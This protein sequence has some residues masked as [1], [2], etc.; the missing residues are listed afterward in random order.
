MLGTRNRSP[1]KVAPVASGKHGYL[2]RMTQL[3]GAMI[4]SA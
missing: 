1:R 3:K 4:S 2:V